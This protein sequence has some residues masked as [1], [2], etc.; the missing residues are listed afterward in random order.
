VSQQINLFNPIFLQRKKYFSAINMAIALGLV[1]A[2]S[3]A[4]V[5]YAVVQVAQ[6]TKDAAVASNQLALAQ[7]ELA[8]VTAEFGPRPKSASLQEDVQKT[9]TELQSLQQ[10]S[11]I[12]KKGD[13]GDTRGYSEYLRAFARQSID[14][15]WLTG[16]TIQGAGNE[17][18]LQGRALRPELV[19]GYI[20]RL[21]TEPVLKGKSFAALEME[22][23]QIDE[24]GA[25][26]STNAAP[27]KKVAAP[28]IE[29]SLHSG[30]TSAAAANPGATR[31]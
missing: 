1:L 23:P 17:I 31:K 8:K 2:G 4:V 21:K 28:F 29:F 9:S 11:G 12:L 10:I 7:A 6:L 25:S 15:L 20:N 5:G 18:A 16:V 19:P 22:V 27:P 24:E 14:G 30:G 26:A 3:L 13:F